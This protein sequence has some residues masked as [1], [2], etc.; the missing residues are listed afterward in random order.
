MDI[1]RHVLDTYFK[2]TTNPMVRH[3]LDSFRDFL[4]TKIPGLVRGLNPLSLIQPDGRKIDVYIG[5]KDGTKLRY[6]PPTEEDGTAIVPHACRLD[7][8]SYMLT[9]LFPM[10]IWMDFLMNLMNRFYIEI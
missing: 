6:L 9:F 4:S 8:K 2:D 3:H 7:N 10:S 1:A 5:G